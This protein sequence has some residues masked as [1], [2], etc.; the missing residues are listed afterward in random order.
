LGGEVFSQ[1]VFNFGFTEFP[2]LL[3]R[4]CFIAWPLEHGKTPKLEG[5]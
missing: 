1:T 5:F 3:I 4:I 2:E